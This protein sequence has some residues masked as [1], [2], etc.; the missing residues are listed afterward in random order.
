MQIEPGEKIAI[1]ASLY[2]QADELINLSL[3]LE[4]ISPSDDKIFKKVVQSNEAMEY[5]F[6]QYSQPGTYL[7]KGAYKNLIAQAEI[8]VATVKQVSVKYENESVFVENIGNVPFIDELTFILQNELKKYAITKKISVDPGKILSIDLSKEVPT[9]VY[10]VLAPFKESL[11]PFKESLNESLQNFLTNEAEEAILA[12]DVTIHDNRPLY[13][14][15]GTV[16]SSINANITGANGLLAKNP[17]IAPIA[18]LIILS[19]II[20]RYGRKPIMNLFKRKKDD[21]DKE[22]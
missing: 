2:D 12:S 21:E 17:F 9:G 7:L 16:L 1:T 3:D 18:L 11:Q 4:L 5:E 10:S 15:M 6:S 20:F 19:L 22:S 8:T 14:R 13:K